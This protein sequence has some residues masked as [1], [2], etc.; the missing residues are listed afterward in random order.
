MGYRILFEA[1]QGFD[2]F[3]PNQLIQIT[4]NLQW[5]LGTC[6]VWDGKL[7]SCIV[8]WF[9]KKSLAKIEFSSITVLDFCSIFNLSGVATM[10]C[11]AAVINGATLKTLVPHLLLYYC[12]KSIR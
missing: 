7:P 1:T 3:M 9:G 2:Q 4:S 6:H 5:S 12:P 10:S 11:G 8:F